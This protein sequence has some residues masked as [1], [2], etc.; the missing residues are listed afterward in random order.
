MRNV[1]REDPK[2]ARE[3]E[4]QDVRIEGSS[5]GRAQPTHSGAQRRQREGEQLLNRLL[6]CA[7]EEEFADVIIGFGIRRGSPLFFDALQ[8][9]RAERE[10]R[11]RAS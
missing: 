9:F 6:D 2:E 4:I 1:K 11:A 7:S 8:A 10:R 3:R 5:R